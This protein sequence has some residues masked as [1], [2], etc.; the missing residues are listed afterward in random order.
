[1]VA[2]DLL[3][4]WPAFPAR[5]NLYVLTIQ[6]HSEG[7]ALWDLENHWMNEAVLRTADLEESLW[8]SVQMA[9]V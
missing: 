4:M 9:S 6:G 8:A 1:M 2:Y 3:K 5:C 7:S